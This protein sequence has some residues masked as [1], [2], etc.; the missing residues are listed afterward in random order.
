MGK[1]S[2]LKGIN[3]EYSLEGLMLKLNTFWPPDVK[4]RLT[5]KD[6]DP[7]QDWR[8]EEKETT[9]DE[10]VGSHHRLSEHEFEQAPGDG[11][12]QGSLACCRPWGH[13]ES[14]TTEWLN[15]NSLEWEGMQKQGRRPPE[16]RLKELKKLIRRL[17]KVRLK[18]YG[19]CIHPILIATPPLKHCYKT[20]HQILPAWKLIIFEA[21]AHFAP[22]CL[23]K[24]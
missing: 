10:M 17:S 16:A 11:D 13:K 4:S 24:Q 18:D 6:P 15:N 5:G 8:Q 19:L 21:Q 7:G 14:D 20:P 3:P 2:I 12:G 23:A 22:L 1:Q 9:V